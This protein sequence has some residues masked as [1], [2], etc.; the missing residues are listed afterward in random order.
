M[1]PEGFFEKWG[2][3]YNKNMAD[4]LAAVITAAVA[5]ERERCAKVADEKARTANPKYSQA[6]YALAIAAAIRA[7]K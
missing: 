4:D 3:K 1:T 5:A 2:L 6:D 7:L